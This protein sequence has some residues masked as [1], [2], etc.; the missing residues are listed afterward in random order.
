MKRTFRINGRKVTIYSRRKKE[1]SKKKKAEK[2]IYGIF[3]L[4]MLSIGVIIMIS[5]NFV[6]AF[7]NIDLAYIYKDYPLDHYNLLN[8]ESR[9]ANELYSDGWKGIFETVFILIIFSIMLIM[10][11]IIDLTEK[12]H[13]YK[14]KF[15]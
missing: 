5:M 1:L 4:I 13:K 6:F 9:T 11:F 2:N 7:H 15:R 10:Y 12:Y 14:K 3:L 8:N